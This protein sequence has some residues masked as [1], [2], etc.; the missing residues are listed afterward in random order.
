M[1][2]IFQQNTLHQL[3]K[4]SISALLAQIAKKRPYAEI[5]CRI[6]A[7]EPALQHLK[8]QHKPLWR[9]PVITLPGLKLQFVQ[10]GED[11]PVIQPL[12]NQPF[13]LFLEGGRHLV[14]PAL[15]YIPRLQRDP[16]LLDAIVKLQPDIPRQS[17]FQEP[18]LQ[19]SLVVSAERVRQR[20][21]RRQ[22][23]PVPAGTGHKSIRQFGA[24]FRGFL[25]GQFVADDSQAAIYR[26]LQRNCPR[27]GAALIAGEIFAVKDREN[28][29]NIQTAIQEY[30][31]IGGVIETSVGGGERL[32][33]QL[34]DMLRVAAGDK[35]VAGIREQ[36]AGHLA[37][38]ESVRRCKGPLHLIEHHA[39]AEGCAILIQFIMPPFLTEY[40]RP[41]VEQR[42][43]HCVHIDPQE[44]D[45]ILVIPAGY[46]IKGP[47]RECHGV[48]ER[49]ERAFHQLHK[50]LLYRVAF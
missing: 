25:G 27:R 30:V 18:P 49:I 34:R 29:P 46:R 24:A 21:Q 47:I 4:I 31:G 23:L 14:H 3:F 6:S 12:P 11:T 20:L 35:S 43:Q 48:Q 22:C 32:I 44:I 26:L 8:T 39:L 40:L 10:C 28:F 37:L 7:V 19:R 13:Q 42:V 45:K 36:A 2:G 9:L 33:G 15:I 41:G 50:R 17:A 1:V 38:Q 16:W 5:C